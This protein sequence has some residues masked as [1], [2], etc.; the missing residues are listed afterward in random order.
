M[1]Y[2]PAHDGSGRVEVRCETS[3][4]LKDTGRLNYRT[5]EG[6]W[7]GEMQVAQVYPLHSRDLPAVVNQPTNTD[8]RPCALASKRCL[9]PTGTK[10]VFRCFTS[11]V[12]KAS[13]LHR[14]GE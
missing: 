12:R 9:K 13:A 3:T 11:E 14:R 1:A 2:L 4:K 10:H 8:H 7:R 6:C 5:V